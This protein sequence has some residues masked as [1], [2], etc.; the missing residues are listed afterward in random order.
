MGKKRNF[1]TTINQNSKF[2]PKKI[3]TL[4]GAKINRRLKK[5]FHEYR[6]KKY[7]IG[8]NIKRIVFDRKLNKLVALLSAYKITKL[9]SPPKF[10]NNQLG[11]G[12]KTLIQKKRYITGKP[13]LK[14]IEKYH[15]TYIFKK[16]LSR[17]ASNTVTSGVKVLK[18]KIR[19]LNVLNRLRRI[20]S[21]IYRLPDVS[22]YNKLTQF[23]LIRI[24]KDCLDLAQ[25]SIYHRFLFRKPGFLIKRL[26]RKKFRR[27]KLRLGSSKKKGKKRYIYRNKKRKNNSRKLRK[28]NLVAIITNS[29]ESL[30]L[31]NQFRQHK[32]QSALAK[33][34]K[35]KKFSLNQLSRR[36]VLTSLHFRRIRVGKRIC[37]SLNPEKIRNK[38]LFKRVLINVKK[39]RDRRR[40]FLF[41]SKTNNNIFP[42]LTGYSGNVIT[43]KSAGN[44]KI[45]TKKKKKAILDTLKAVSKVVVTE[46]RKKNIRFIYPFFTDT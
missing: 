2:A 33:G 26:L 29:I 44:C 36:I 5:S 11:S 3:I 17:S 15:K 24:S 43:S 9:K 7:S 39:N 30:K 34:F 32:S 45:T 41:F 10:L 23:K 27:K 25:F 22:R 37:L 35:N 40:Y 28:I 20:Y 4:K 13:Y 31:F 21:L 16:V 38:K 12:K 42:T 46:T 19:S 14:K 18:G 8:G 1:D 6:V